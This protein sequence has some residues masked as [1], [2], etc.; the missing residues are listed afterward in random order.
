[1]AVES[2]RFPKFVMHQPPEDLGVKFFMSNYVGEAPALSML[3]YLPEFYSKT[4]Y[5]SQGLQQ[6][7]VATGLAGFAKASGRTD[8]QEQATRCYVS[9][10]RGINGALADMRGV[11]QDSTLMAISMCFHGTHEHGQEMD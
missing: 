7:I 6:S 9:A 5:A 11:S 10:I 2:I 1:M 4:G 3:N 8:M